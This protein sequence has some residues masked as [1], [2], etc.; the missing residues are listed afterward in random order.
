MASKK[1][2]GDRH[3][4]HSPDT[5]TRPLD[6]QSHSISVT[7]ASHRRAS[8]AQEDLGKQAALRTLA[9]NGSPEQAAHVCVQTMFRRRHMLFD[10]I[11]IV[12]DREIFVMKPYFPLEG[13]SSLSKYTMLRSEGQASITILYIQSNIGE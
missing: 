11:S 9:F 7:W 4:S 3:E 6:D 10:G 12:I 1:S 8:R 2:V 13:S 5:L